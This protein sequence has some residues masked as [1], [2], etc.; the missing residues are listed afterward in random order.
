MCLVN[1]PGKK[2]A[3]WLM[4]DFFRCD[5]LTKE[6]DYRSSRIYLSG[7]GMLLIFILIGLIR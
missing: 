6:N 5:M 4:W 3:I 1:R 7:L 2:P